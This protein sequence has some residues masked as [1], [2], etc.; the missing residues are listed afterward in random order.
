MK[1][2]KL[3]HENP[4]EF[5][6]TVMELFTEQIT[7]MMSTYLSLGNSIGDDELKMLATDLDIIFPNEQKEIASYFKKRNFEELQT[8]LLKKVEEYFK[9]KAK[10]VG[11]EIWDDVVRSIFLSIVDQYWTEH[12]TAIEDLREGINLRGYAQLDPLVEYKN[13]AF[14]M[15]ERLVQSINYE[16]TRR[17]FRVEVQLNAPEIKAEEKEVKKPKKQKPLILK[18]ASAINPFSAQEQKAVDSPLPVQATPEDR[19]Y[20]ESLGGELGVKITAPGTVKEHKLGRNDPCWCGSGKKY[21]KCHY[22]Q[23]SA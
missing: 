20:T 19:Q 21:K 22:I 9:Q 5:R 1:M 3:A 15:F 2:V 7:S 10:Q 16:F 13:E 17:L 23:D 6:A 4:E 18:S 8:F 11:N 14:K 12:L